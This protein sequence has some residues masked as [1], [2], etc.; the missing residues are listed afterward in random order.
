M[1]YY[2]LIDK[3]RK[4]EKESRWMDALIAW[5]QAEKSISRDCPTL[6]DRIKNEDI[7]AVILIIKSRM[8]GDEFRR[9]ASGLYEK[10]E[11]REINNRELY[12]ALQEADKKAN[13]YYK[14]IN[15]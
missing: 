6:A 2:D 3:A 14:T 11:S 1:M 13:E 9:L 15:F 10:H 12:E 8:R 7:P 4:A 5:K